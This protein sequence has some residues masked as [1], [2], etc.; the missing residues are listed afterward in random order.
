LTHGGVCVWSN[1]GAEVT[2][3]VSVTWPGW[4]R[5]IQF[6]LL[7]HAHNN[8]LVGGLLKTLV[9]SRDRVSSDTYRRKGVVSAGVADGGKGEVFL[10]RL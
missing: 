10:F 3:T 7:L 8:V 9:F 2:L 4:S 6:N 1:G 5:E